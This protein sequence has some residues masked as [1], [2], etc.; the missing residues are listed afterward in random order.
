MQSD[1]PL[2]SSQAVRSLAPILF[3]TSA[4]LASQWM[5]ILDYRHTDVAEIEITDWAGRFA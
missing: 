4:K 5:K 2:R 3:E 1:I